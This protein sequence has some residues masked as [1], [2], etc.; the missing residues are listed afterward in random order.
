MRISDWSSDVC[1]SDLGK[2]KELG[3]QGK[4]TPGVIADALE[5]EADRIDKE[6]E[7]L[8]ETLSSAGAKFSTAL[9]VMIGQE[10]QALGFTTVLAEGLA[11]LA[12][13]LSSP[14]ERR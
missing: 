14:E 11:F 8:P 6:L 10:D 2:L 12:A 9:N 5:K 1:S 7:R 13:N 4:L 3:K